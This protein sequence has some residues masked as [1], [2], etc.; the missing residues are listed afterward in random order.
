MWFLCIIIFFIAIIWIIL[1]ANAK[2]KDSQGKE[3]ISETIGSLKNE[4]NEL[5]KL[6]S[7]IEEVRKIEKDSEA[8]TVSYYDDTVPKEEI[9]QVID[10]IK[11]NE[12]TANEVIFLKFMNNKA[13]NISFSPRWEFQYELKPRVE[14]AKLLKLEYLTYSSW[15][16]NVKNATMKELKEILKS[17]DLKISG[18]KQELVERVLGNIDADL[19]EEKF[20]KGKYKL[21]NKGNKIIEKNK[22]LFMSDREKAGKEFEELTDTE[23]KQL[24]VFH[25]VNEYKRLKHNELAFEKGYSK[26]DILWSI[27][28]KQKDIYIRQKDYTMVGVV[29]DCMS[30]I[31]DKEKRYEQEI[32]FLICCMYFKSYEILPNDAIIDSVDYYESRI[33]K[34]CQYLKKLMKKCNKDIDDF[35]IRHNFIT[36][37]IEKI[38][39]HYVPKIF[40]DYEKI[41]KFQI[42][43]NEFIDT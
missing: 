9:K 12:L 29:Y 14:L 22:R 17:K 28:N 5:N 37:E 21:T 42:K 40:L 20:N 25:K 31:V 27:Y 36:N 18:N 6:I 24:Q 39:Q 11:N 8:D 1:D 16:D 10:N 15:H 23:Y 13:I 2:N 41:S 19:L 34:H 7:Q 3:E 30:D 33:K 26:N 35:N 43:I 32:H 4:Y 38:L